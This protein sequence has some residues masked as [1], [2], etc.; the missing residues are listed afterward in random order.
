MIKRILT[1]SV[2]LLAL[3]LC[4]GLVSCGASEI[5]GLVFENSTVVYDGAE[6]SVAVTGAPEGAVISYSPAATFTDAGVYNVTATVKADGY[7]DTTV[8]AVLTIAPKELFVEWGSLSFPADG[9]TQTP[10]YTLSGFIGED[11]CEL[12]FDFGGCE[13][14]KEG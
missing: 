5:E 8:S 14:K 3:A 2:L 13:F 7:A 1:L 6:H 12:E 9:K 10:T 11:S 4:L